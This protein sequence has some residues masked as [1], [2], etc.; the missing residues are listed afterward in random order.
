MHR[1]DGRVV[2]NLQGVEAIEKSITLHVGLDVRKE[3]IDIAAPTLIVRT[4]I[5]FFSTH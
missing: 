2:A 1:T 4:P 5:A 3:S